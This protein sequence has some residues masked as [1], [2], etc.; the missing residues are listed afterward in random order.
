MA[1]DLLK[2][3][4]KEFVEKMNDVSF[5]WPTIALSM[6]SPSNWV[7]SSGNSTKEMLEKLADEFCPLRTA[8]ILL[9]WDL[10]KGIWATTSAGIWLKTLLVISWGV[11]NIEFFAIFL[12]SC[13]ALYT[14]KSVGSG[15]WAPWSDLMTTLWFFIQR[16]PLQPLLTQTQPILVLLG[17][18][19]AW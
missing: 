17:A 1:V 6:F 2:I 3:S 12:S 8:R 13:L 18:D 7:S 4:T 15:A 5:P 10:S 19:E 16:A 9:C 11:K 14:W